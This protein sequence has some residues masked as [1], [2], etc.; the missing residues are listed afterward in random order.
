VFEIIVELRDKTISLT[1]KRIN[2]LENNGKAMQ[3]T[4]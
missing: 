2:N 1:I 3:C 4:F